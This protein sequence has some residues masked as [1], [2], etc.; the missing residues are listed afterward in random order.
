MNK[1]Q[2]GSNS[3]SQVRYHDLPPNRSTKG[4]KVY[5]IKNAFGSAGKQQSCDFQK[6]CT[7]EG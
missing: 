2:T 7:A 6:C 4:D 5:M 1:K 3:A